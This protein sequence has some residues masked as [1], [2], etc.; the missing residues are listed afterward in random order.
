MSIEDK[1]VSRIDELIEKGNKALATHKPNP[2]NVIGFT[3]LDSGAFAE[4]QTQVQNFLINLLEQNHVYVHNFREKVKDGYQSHVKIG[5]GIL[6]AVKEDVLGG[7][8]FN[9]KTLISAEVFTDFLE[10]SEHLLECGY[11]DP[12]AS[13]CGAVLEDGLRRIALNARIKLKNKEDLTSLNHKCADV[14]VY[15]R[16]VQRKIQVWIDIRNNA[17]HGKFNEYSEIDV[18]EMLKGVKNFLADFLR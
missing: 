17:D 9:I 12:A 11:K 8:L 10:M 13:L 18:Q 6:R 4:W 7:Y 1:I 16:L 3:T 14:E 2:P 5:Q 15:N